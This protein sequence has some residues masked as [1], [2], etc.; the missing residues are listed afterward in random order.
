MCRLYY[1][2]VCMA[3]SSRSGRPLIS[4]TSKER[5]YH[6]RCLLLFITCRRV[7][8]CERKRR[9]FVCRTLLCMKC[10]H[11]RRLILSL[12]ALVPFAI[13]PPSL[14][15]SLILSLSLSVCLSLSCAHCLEPAVILAV[16]H[17]SLCAADSVCHAQ[18][19]VVH[20]GIW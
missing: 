4:K 8:S 2:T 18:S 15:H 20:E 1:V 6:I 10:R 9:N 19:S 12:S 11:L 16:L 13:S 5:P 17:H 3:T 14:S 7:T